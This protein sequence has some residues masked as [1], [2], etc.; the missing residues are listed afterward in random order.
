MP[1]KG[2]G[3][4]ANKVM[5]NVKGM[6]LSQHGG[7]LIFDR[8]VADHSNPGH[9]LEYRIRSLVKPGVPGEEDP[10]DFVT[11]A[12]RYGVPQGRHRVI[13]F[14]IR[15]DVARSVSEPS[16]KLKEFVLKG[17]NMNMSVGEAFSGLP[18]LRSRLSRN[19]IE[20]SHPKSDAA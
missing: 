7:S 15:S 19:T 6:L 9:G 2:F 12:E 20:L 1:N 17:E 10:H 16:S 13:L 11:E 3:A 18:S 4:E 5:E 8:I 14:G